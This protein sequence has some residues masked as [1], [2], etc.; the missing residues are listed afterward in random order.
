[1][2]NE[3]H[4]LSRVPPSPPAED[5]GNYEAIHAAV[6]E[7]ARGRWFLQEYAQRNR[8]ADTRQV[9]AAIQRLESVVGAR[10]PSSLGGSQGFRDELLDMARAIARTRIEVR[11]AREGRE[12]REGRSEPAAQDIAAAS[13]GGVPAAPSLPPDV[14]AAA[15]RIQEVAW[16][17]RERGVELSTCD[18]I[19]TLASSILGASSLRN[20]NDS[21]AQKL[22]E[23]LQHLERRINSMLDSCGDGADASQPEAGTD[24]RAEPGALIEPVPEPPAPEAAEVSVVEEVVVAASDPPLPP[25]E[26]TPQLAD[27]HQGE[28]AS[29]PVGELRS[30]V[31]EQ[32]ET[33]SVADPVEAAAVTETQ[34][35]ANVSAESGTDLPPDAA[36]DTELAVS[37]SPQAP[38]AESPSSEFAPEPEPPPVQEASAELEPVVFEFE[39]LVVVPAGAQASFAPDRVEL[40]LPPVAVSATAGADQ[41]APAPSELEPP[42]A[43]ASLDLREDANNAAG[44][45]ETDM[46][47]MARAALPEPQPLSSDTAP[48]AA[49]G[50]EDKSPISELRK[51]PS[52]RLAAIRAMSDSERIALFS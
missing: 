16:T 13:P 48:S 11:D 21:R 25:P 22:N 44:E 10:S 50:D 35:A 12:G 39:P 45:G 31:P 24:T 2:S 49:Q 19:A 6:M 47:A 28:L 41:I 29:E 40:D 5:D 8:H 18:Q 38:A 1:M 26:Q 46:L 30:A 34:L 17:M 42:C 27:D 15:N 14:F 51:P 32:S 4:A 36:Q 3:S 9:L 23:V 20:A 33:A 37:A 7:T 43:P 52:D